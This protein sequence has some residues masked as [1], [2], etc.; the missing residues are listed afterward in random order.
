MK[1]LLS[2]LLSLLLL[3]SFTS[4]L[5]GQTT[6]TGFIDK[7]PIELV[8]DLHGNGMVRAFYVYTKFD[9]PIII[10]GTLENDLLSLFEKDS[11][12]STTATLVFKDFKI[13][14]TTINGLWKDH[15]TK[16]ELKITLTKVFEVDFGGRVHWENKELLQPVSIKDRYFKLV[17][18]KVRGDFYVKVTG[19]K[20]FEKKTDKLIQ[21][22]SNIECQ[23]WGLDNISIDD[24]NFDGVIDFSIF[25]QS[26][27]GPNTSR[28]YF[29][30]NS[31][32]GEYFKSSFKGTS[33]EF[34]QTT[35]RIYEHNQSCAG[36]F[37]MNA[38]Y[39]VINNKMV[40]IK[41]TCLAYD[42][43]TEEYINVKC[44]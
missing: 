3:V 43:K 1:S 5:N 42:E 32:T 31:K 28:L 13:D 41:K 36:Y 44:E 21:E 14:S 35:K 17:L 37:H 4:I 16:K 39:K 11:L 23:L 20:I 38:E 9:N 27:A 18:S 26:Y 15:K 40:L 25:E 29:L 22:I 2:F 8:T 7:Y 6:Y 30:F 24:Y 33:L 10:D 12:D 34:D 19:V